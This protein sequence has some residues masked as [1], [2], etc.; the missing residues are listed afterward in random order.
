M[1]RSVGKKVPPE[2]CLYWLPFHWLFL[3][4][5][6]YYF[7]DF[8]SRSFIKEKF[9]RTREVYKASLFFNKYEYLHVIK[10]VYYVVLT[11][12]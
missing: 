3:N 4:L 6:R 10:E 1:I 5:K 8:G 7:V 11:K 12:V 9:K 2:W